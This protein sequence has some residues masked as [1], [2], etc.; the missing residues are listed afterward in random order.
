ML[1]INKM[2]TEGANEKYLEI[3]NQLEHLDGELLAFFQYFKFKY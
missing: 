2:D 3:K 1:I